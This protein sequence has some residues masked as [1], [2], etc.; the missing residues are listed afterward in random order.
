[1]R[2]PF[3]RSWTAESL[4]A[5]L[6][7]EPTPPASLALLTAA[8]LWPESVALTPYCGCAHIFDG[9]STADLE[10]RH[11]AVMVAP[12]ATHARATITRSW[13][14]S[15]TTASTQYHELSTTTGGS[16]G[17]DVLRLQGPI[18]FNVVPDPLWTGVLQHLLDSGSSVIDSPASGHPDRQLEVAT[19][20]YPYVE[21]VHVTLAS[22]FSAA[23]SLLIEDV[24]LL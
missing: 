8:V 1:M 11:L 23:T 19:L 2:Q 5:A 13:Q 7:G 21:P 6:V 12:G 15:P 24:E 9:A 14:P 10:S 17:A 3:V 4:T 18:V 16:S 22:G 20:G